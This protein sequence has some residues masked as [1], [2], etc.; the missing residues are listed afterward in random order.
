MFFVL[1]AGILAEGLLTRFL[2]MILWNSDILGYKNQFHS[3]I[4]RGPDV[5]HAIQHSPHFLNTRWPSVRTRTWP[6]HRLQP[7]RR[8]FRAVQRRGGERQSDHAGFGQR[9]RPRCNQDHDKLP[10]HTF[11]TLGRF[12]VWLSATGSTGALAAKS[13][14][15]ERYMGQRDRAPC[16]T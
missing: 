13:L 12:A 5:S 11:L 10:Y 16:E 4:L 7:V 1:V 3:P 14:R 8:L 9:H 6:D 2:A 15:S